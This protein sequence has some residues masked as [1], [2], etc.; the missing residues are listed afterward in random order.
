MD[1]SSAAQIFA[2][3]TTNASLPIAFATLVHSRV[4]ADVF[5]QLSRGSKAMDIT[6]DGAQS[7][8]Y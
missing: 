7:E 4:Q 1:L 3:M 6:D 5:D 8:G 2:S